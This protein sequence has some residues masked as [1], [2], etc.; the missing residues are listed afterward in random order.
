[1]SKLCHNTGRDCIRDSELPLLFEISML[2]NE[3]STIEDVL[4]NVTK[5][6]AHYISAQKVLLTILD[7]QTETIF[8]EVGYGISQEIAKKTSYSM[9]EGIIGEVIKK[10]VPIHVP[11]I[12]NDSRFL[13]KTKSH[14][15]TNSRNDISFTCVP[16]RSKDAIVG[17]VSI[18]REHGKM[19][20]YKQDIGVLSIIGALI[21][22]TVKI[23]QGKIEEIQVLQ[24]KN[25][26]LEEELSQ[27]KQRPINMIGNSNHMQEVYNLIHM[28]TGTNA[29]VLIR[30]ESGSGKELV[31]E[32]I[33]QLSDR[34]HKPFIKVNCAALP[35]TLI[36]SEL[37]GHEKGAFTGA[38]AQKKGRFELAHTGTIFLDEI[39]DIPLHTQI[40]LLRIIQQ[41]EFERVGGTETITVDV[42]IIAA[43]NRNLE[44]L[45]AEQIFREDL[46][47]RINVFPIV[48][49]PLR[50]RVT[51]IPMLVDHFIEKSNQ[52]NN[53]NIIRISSSAI[54]MLMIYKWPGNIRELENCIKRAAIMSTDGVIRAHNLPPTLQTA[55]SSGTNMKGTFKTIVGNLE[56][57]LI[58]DT[59]TTTNGN[60]HQASEL[61]DLTERIL[62]TRIQKYGI[63]PKR[64]KVK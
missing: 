27:K 10:G 54:D 59:L 12:N 56:K 46:Y 6:I 1:M 39:G 32:A 24:E 58:I 4:S 53:T 45:I 18:E 16:I 52:E 15:L 25:K 36:E 26:Q 63:V 35:E 33:H 41:K 20:D 9:G 64:Y 14:L 11:K 21:A 62:N 7:R 44:Q 28:V 8:I 43:T 40:K 5:L 38:I 61:L 49:P 3:S 19:F 55:D 60:V 42:R 29:S 2:M 47:Y 30:G 37:L 34:K 31:A 51:D 57:Q 22:E 13:N 23:R 48:I 17:A 50:D